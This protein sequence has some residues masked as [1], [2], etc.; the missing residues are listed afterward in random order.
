[1]ATLF[2]LPKVLYTH[3]VFVPSQVSNVFIAVRNAST[4]TTISPIFRHAH[5]EEWAPSFKRCLN[6]LWMK[7]FSR[8]IMLLCFSK[9]SYMTVLSLLITETK[10]IR[11]FNQRHRNTS[12]GYSPE[13]F[14]R[15]CNRDQTIPSFN[16]KQRSTNGHCRFG[17][18][19]LSE[20]YASHHLI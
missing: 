11:S 5:A 12:I 9:F 1:M 10:E 18:P 13:S 2:V 7:L 19:R 16:R 15:V 6:S 14:N 20:M 3:V 4:K 17:I 8:H